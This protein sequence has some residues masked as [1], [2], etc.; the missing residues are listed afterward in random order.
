MVLTCAQTNISILL[1]VLE[2]YPPASPAN[3]ATSGGQL[4]RLRTT[5]VCHHPAKTFLRWLLATIF[6]GTPSFTT[7]ADRTIGCVSAVVLSQLRVIH[8][9]FIRNSFEI[10]C[11]LQYSSIGEGRGRVSKTP[12]LGL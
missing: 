8:Q 5:W 4:S 3:G 11:L 6:V 2:R 10:H 12:L 9:F 7:S 1:Q